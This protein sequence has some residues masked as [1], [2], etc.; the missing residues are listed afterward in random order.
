M[1]KT[2]FE[3]K[4]GSLKIKGLEYHSNNTKSPA[5]IF[6]H[7]FM[8]NMTTVKRYAKL[9]ANLGYAAFCFDFCGGSFIGKSKGKTS[10]MSLLTE[11][12]DLKAVVSYVSQLPYI[13][14]ENISIMGCGQGG[15]VASLVAAELNETIKNLILYYPSFNIPENIK[16]GKFLYKKINKSAIPQF[17]R[18]G[19]V[20]LGKCY[21]SDALNINP[22]SFLSLYKGKV[23]IVHGNLDKIVPFSCSY[24]AHKLLSNKATVSFSIIAGARHF[25]LF[26][27]N[28][29]SK[30]AL[31][32]YLE[33]SA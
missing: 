31:K 1:E 28:K 4:R 14:S 9:C 3:C 15:L 18:I 7:E 12:E 13:D 24:E 25:F 6:C 32:N 5:I 2:K 20:K 8:T 22:Y 26:N 29:L 16:L 11:K 19:P 27:H 33:I 23:L 10:D 17:V 21:F 30:N